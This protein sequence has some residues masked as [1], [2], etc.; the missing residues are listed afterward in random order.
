MSTQ[1]LG[2]LVAV[3]AAA[4]LLSSCALSG[5]GG[6]GGEALD[7]SG[8]VTG[9]VTLQTWALKPRFTD[10]VEGVIDAF[11]REHPGTTVTWLDQP[12]D[13]Y[14]D[15]VLTQAQAGELPDVV[16]IPP[17]Y[18]L[19][20]S[21]Q[22]LVLD[23]S[24]VDDT[25]DDTYVPGALD[26]YRYQG[27]EGTYGYPWYL[28]TDLNYWNSQMMS[29]AGLD[30]TDPPTTLDELVDQARTMRD[31]T[32]GQSYLMS[33]MP[34]LGDFTIA[35][36]PIVDD[37]G[38]EFTFNTPEAVALL[39][40]YVAAYSEGLL[41]PDVLTDAYQGNGELF[42]KGTVAWS[43]GG[44]NFI[45]GTIE[46]NPSLEGLMVPSEY[47]GGGTPLYVQGVAV[48]RQTKNAPAAVALARFLTNAE[49]QERFAS[50]VPGVFPSTLSS[51]ED[52]EFAA[53]D[54]TPEG[55]AK[56]IAF[57]SLVE[58]EIMLPPQ[59]TDAMLTIVAQQFA[60]AM[61]GD[62]TAQQALDTAVERCNQL[63]AG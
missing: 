52:P 33:R 16:N 14:S 48:S 32:G 58:A 26:G 27:K 12:G 21:D 17:E 25:L 7:A 55:D 5:S 34:W 11:E 10:Y 2:A 31:A 63:L 49:N 24:T 44:G 51:Q 53:S 1:R 47:M 23:V 20:L 60:A 22:D 35:G 40:K 46:K 13:G 4:G 29:E 45:A 61:S 8:E 9:E 30:A 50:E 15:K 62:V 54:G 38:D 37:D 43:T 42:A 36:V 6:G 18:G 41:P 39:E 3:V 56:V 57:S 59:V 19:T 28:T